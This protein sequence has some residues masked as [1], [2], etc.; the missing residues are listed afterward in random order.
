MARKV[1]F[2][3]G[4]PKTG[5]T[6]LQ[7]I[8]WN[9]RDRLRELG[10]LLPGASAREHLWASCVV[11]EDHKVSRR[12]PKAPGSWDRLVGEVAEWP[13]DAVI[14]HEFFASATT[15][16]A[17]R[18]IEALAPAEVH[19]V[20][21]GRDSLGLFT[22]SWQESV[23]NGGVT[24]IN[25]YGRQV[26]G[27]PLVIWNW[28]ALDLGLVLDRW[29]QSVPPDHV[30]VLP[31]PQP[32]APRELLWQRF[33]GVL[34]VDPAALDVS[35]NFPNE[36]MGVAETE[37]LRRIN[38]RL[39]GFDSSL[40][41]GVWVRTYL[42]DERLVPRKG[43]KYWPAE[44][45]IEDCRRRGSAAAEL[46]RERGFDVVGNAQDLLT[47]DTLPPR[48]HPDSVTDA[49]VAAVAV[50]TVAGMLGDVRRLTRELHHSRRAGRT[51]LL[52]AAYRRLRRRRT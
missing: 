28:R 32:G 45:Q 21:T 3:I 24:P 15:E 38:E 50:E 37:T 29:S 7:T 31:L 25:D 34:G 10:V 43:D 17:T 52:V 5:T 1:F 14:S 8:M 13:G 49:E 40:D 44:D 36:S 16:Q 48:R 6:Y 51:P 26:S 42:A 33:A 22:A 11:R 18:A 30:H 46:I 19:V 39:D 4:L 2:H 27:N 20:V 12:D 47:P 35:G 41:R 23:K 9:N